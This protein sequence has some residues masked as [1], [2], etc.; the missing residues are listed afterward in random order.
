MLPRAIP[1]AR[2]SPEPPRPEPSEPSP[3]DFGSSRESEILAAE[4]RRA[5]GS[6]VRF[7][8]AHAALGIVEAFTCNCV[9]ILAFS[10]MASSFF[11]GAFGLM[12]RI[13]L[14]GVI[15]RGAEALERRRKRGLAMTAGI[16][17]LLVSGY[18]ILVGSIGMLN[19]LLLLLPRRAPGGDS[20]FL[21]VSTA[22]TGVVAVLGLIGGIKTLV[23]LSNPEVS[24][25]FRR[26]R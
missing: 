11:A 16:L 18:L 6:A 4:D 15:F 25:S 12:L 24:R 19:L 3:F 13:V 5:I 8:K 17:A 10:A 26:S 14:L 1:L 7:L 21:L 22:V 20:S 2:P 9:S 23:V